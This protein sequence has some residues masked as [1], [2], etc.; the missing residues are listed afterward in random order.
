MTDIKDQFPVVATAVRVAM[1]DFYRLGIGAAIEALLD[2]RETTTDPASF[3]AVIEYL[4]QFSVR[5]GQEVD[6]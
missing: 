4:R 5:I 6:Q 3:D 1:N 2:F